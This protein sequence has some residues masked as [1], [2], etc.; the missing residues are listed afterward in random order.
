MAT[1]LRIWIAATLGACLAVAIGALSGGPDVAPPSEQLSHHPSAE[2]GRRAAELGAVWRTTW[3]RW[4]LESYRARLAPA[5]DSARAAGGTAPLLLIE[6]PSTPAQR[7]E[8]NRDLATI[9]QQGAPEG[10]KVAVALVI[11]R[12]GAGGAG[13]DTPNPDARNVSL[14]YLFPDSLHRDMCLA[15][16]HEASQ[17]RRFFQVGDLSTVQTTRWLA[18]SLGPCAFYGTYGIPGHEIGR[19]LNAEGMGYAIYPQWWARGRSPWFGYTY[20]DDTPIE[21]RPA[22]WWVFMYSLMPWDGAACYGGRVTQCARN[23]FDSAAVADS[24][25]GYWDESNWYQEPEHPFFSGVTYLS[26]LARALGPARF[27]EFWSSDEPMDSALHL[28]TGKSLGDWTLSWARTTGPTLHLGPAAPSLDVFWGILPA[29]LA[30]GCA[31]WYAGRRQI[32]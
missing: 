13:P 23:V 24:Q 30:F 20:Y 11:I 27:S 7:S 17:G 8:L 6:G 10:F 26:D 4:R 25:P 22:G 3:R 21:R 12:D 1:G 29:L 14:T 2:W 19:W 18:E 9:W 16:V 28:A 5:A 15:V 32:G 31:L